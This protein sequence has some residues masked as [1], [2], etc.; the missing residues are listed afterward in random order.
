MSRDNAKSCTIAARLS[1][2]AH[3]LQTVRERRQ[4]LREKNDSARRGRLEPRMHCARRMMNKAIGATSVTRTLTLDHQRLD[5]LFEEACR[6]AGDGDFARAGRAFGELARGLRHHIDVEERL[7]FP[8]FDARV[9][10]PGPTTVMRHEH[11]AIDELLGVA[12]AAL[13]AGEGALFAR[14]AAELTALLRAHNL[15]EERVLY[16]RCDAALDEQEQAGVVAALARA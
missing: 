13:A 9:P 4:R 1:D 11:R 15:K 8:A 5:Q 14:E 10:M 2:R 7:L 16:P 12:Q 6:F 3:A